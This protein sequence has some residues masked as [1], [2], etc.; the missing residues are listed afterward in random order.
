MRTRIKVLGSLAAT[1]LLLVSGSA[2][3]D[4]IVGSAHDFTDEIAGQNQICVY[5]HTPHNAA[6]TTPGPL[7]N[8]ATYTPS[9][10]TMYV[11][12]TIDGTID[13]Q[14]TGTSQLC[15]SCHDGTVAIDSYGGATGTIT[16]GNAVF[17]PGPGVY[18]KNLTNEHPISITYPANGVAPAQEM[19]LDTNPFTY[20]DTTP[21][22]VSQLLDGGKV[23]CSSCHD[24]HNTKTAVG[25][26][27]LLQIN[28][29]GTA[30]SP[31]CL[32]C[33]AK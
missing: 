4:T 2:I 3:A 17:A 7:W 25:Q 14:P 16:I 33:H 27:F 1:S 12:T 11:S 22:T 18:D 5:C 9:G 20:G 8:R 19:R 6:A 28:N 32:A 26:P 13:G 10:F 29:T 24:V 30:G 23:Q 15:L 31:L 21:G